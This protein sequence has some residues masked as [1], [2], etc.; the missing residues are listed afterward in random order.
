MRSPAVLGHHMCRLGVIRPQGKLLEF[1]ISEW[2]VERKEVKREVN[3]LKSQV[4][5]PL[6]ITNRMK[7]R[8]TERRT[9]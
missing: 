3:S 4:G 7:D 2:L 1:Q 5:N 9:E 6:N 8:Q